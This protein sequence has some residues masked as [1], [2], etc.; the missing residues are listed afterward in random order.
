MAY[1]SQ[2]GGDAILVRSGNEKTGAYKENIIPILP[3]ISAIVCTDYNEVKDLNKPTIVIKDYQKAFLALA[4]YMR[5]N[6]RKY[7]KKWVGT[8]YLSAHPQTDNEDEMILIKKE[9]KRL[10]LPYVE[11]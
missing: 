3:L 9:K 11:Y 4:K 6:Y 7:R 2:G 1:R 5:G 10:K 8:G